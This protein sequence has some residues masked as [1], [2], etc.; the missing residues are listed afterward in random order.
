MLFLLGGM[1][2]VLLLGFWMANSM[3]P[4]EPAAVAVAVRGASPDRSM[5]WLFALAAWATA[6]FVRPWWVSVPLAAIVV[7]VGFLFVVI[8][9]LVGYSD[10]HLRPSQS[11]ASITLQV[12][13]MML[14]SRVATF[15]VWLRNPSPEEPT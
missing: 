2:A 5:L 7:L 8:G 10:S 13:L 9:A 14:A 15:L 11:T 3:V 4:Q 1:G 6:F 12:G